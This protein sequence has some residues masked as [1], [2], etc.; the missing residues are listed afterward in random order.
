MEEKWKVIKDSNNRYIIS[1]KGKVLDLYKNKYCS[2]YLR[3]NKNARGRP[4]VS[5]RLLLNNNEEKVLRLAC[6][7]Y[8]YFG[9]KPYNIYKQKI[10]IL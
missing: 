2:I 10:R 3:Q 8:N 9:D 4:C 6:L 5:V 7:V 1:N